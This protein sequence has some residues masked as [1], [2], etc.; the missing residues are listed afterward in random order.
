[1]DDRIMTAVSIAA[2]ASIQEVVLAG[3]RDNPKLA[4]FALDDVDGANSFLGNSDGL[5][6]A[7]LDYPHDADIRP[8]VL[9]KRQEHFVAASLNHHN[10]AVTRIFPHHNF[11]AASRQPGP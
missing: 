8:N 5:L 9:A 2:I 6:H 4:A 10:M 7:L 11:Y 1:M 3:H